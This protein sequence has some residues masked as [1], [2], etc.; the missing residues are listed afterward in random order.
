GGVVYSMQ[1]KGPPEWL[2]TSMQLPQIRHIETILESFE[3]LVSMVERDY[4]RRSG[5]LGLISGLIGG[6]SSYFIFGPHVTYGVLGLFLVDGI[7]T[8]VG[9]NF[10]SKRVPFTAKTVEGTLAGFLSF[11][12]ALA[13]ITGDFLNALIVASV[14]SLAELY[15]IE[16]N[17]TVPLT[18]S[19]L[20]YLMVLP[21]LP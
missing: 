12:I 11:L 2:R 19:A 6:S 21:P 5:W 1:V 15:G 13:L 14:S 10:G 7:S 20:A 18:S 9:M 4:E 8:I 17:I 16:D 3:R